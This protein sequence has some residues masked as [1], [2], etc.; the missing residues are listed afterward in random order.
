MTSG[1]YLITNKI[2]NHMYVGGSIDIERRFREHKRGADVDNQAIDRAI[3]KYGKEN[4]T[5][6]IITELPPDW[7]IISKHEKY[8]VKFYNTFK[9]K[10]HYNL[11]DGGDSGYE[12]N[13]HSEET[14]NK[15][16]KSHIG[17]THSEE[18]KKKMSEAHKGKNHWNYG[19]ITPDKTKIKISEKLRKD[20][21]R[22]IKKG[23]THNRQQYAIIFNGEIIRRSTNI[24]LLKKWFNDNYP[25]EELVI[26]ESIKYQ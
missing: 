10:H 18:T 23:F 20:Y 11:K 21:P 2:N 3:L 13:T 6:Q 4:F 19:N 16:S 14:R 17:N 22:I 8:W 26:D 9:N 24:G 15:M 5:Y 12:G 25:D 7:K 1:I